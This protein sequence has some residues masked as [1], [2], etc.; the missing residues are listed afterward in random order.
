MERPLSLPTSRDQCPDNPPDLWL[1]EG[2]WP[3]M[4]DSQ[5]SCLPLNL[6]ASV[7]ASCN[8]RRVAQLYISFLIL[9]IQT[10]TVA[11]L[12]NMFWTDCRSSCR[13]RSIT[14]ESWRSVLLESCVFSKFIRN[15]LY[16]SAYRIVSTLELLMMAI[17]TP[18]CAIYLCIRMFA[19]KLRIALSCVGSAIFLRDRL[20]IVKIH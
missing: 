2:V 1:S 14:S 16:L 19:L 13:I 11:C 12:I 10:L 9:Q 8:T 7:T 20:M 4:C 18:K 5:L 15:L 6:R 17:Y 3:P